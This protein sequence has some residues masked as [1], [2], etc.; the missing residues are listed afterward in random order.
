M[1]TTPS[2][3]RATQCIVA[4]LIAFG[5]FSGCDDDGAQLDGNVFLVDDSPRDLQLIVI[6]PPTGPLEGGALVA[7]VGEGF[8]AEMTVM[9]GERQAT[10]IA[11]GGDSVAIMSTPPGVLPGAVDVV[12]TR[13]SDGQTSTLNG[14]YSYVPGPG[15]LLVLEAIPDEGPVAGGSK[16]T[17]NGS[18]FVEGAEVFFGDKKATG[19]RVLGNEALTL[20]VPAGAAL[21]ATNI[22]VTLPE[23]DSHTLERGYTYFPEG[24]LGKVE[25][26]GV[27]PSTGPLVGGNIVTVEG[28]GFVTGTTVS[29]GNTA[30]T[31]VRVLGPDAITVTV[32]EGTGPGLVEVRVNVPANETNETAVAAFLENAYAYEVEAPTQLS[33]LNVI[34][35]Q[36]PL[37]GG[38]TVALR[39]SGFEEGTKVFF[40][41]MAALNVQQLGANG[42]TAIMPE[43][44]DAGAVD[45]RVEL[46]DGGDAVLLDDGYTYEPGTPPLL[47]LEA[48]PLTGPIEGG[49]VVALKGE[50]FID[51][52]KVYFGGTRGTSVRVL[53]STAITVIAPLSSAPGLVDLRVE[54]PILPGEDAGEAY[55]LEDA[56]TYLLGNV[57]GDLSVNSLF[58]TQDKEEG[59]ALVL[60]TGTGFDPAM[61]VTFGETQS[62]LTQV[63]SGNAATALVPAGMA[64][65]LDVRLSNPTGEAVQ[66]TNGFRYITDD[67]IDLTEPP[68]LGAVQPARGPASGGTIVRISG[69]N[70]ADDARIFFGDVESTEVNVSSTSV[71]SAVVPAGALGS[72]A[73]RVVNPDDQEDVLAN[74]FV[75]AD[76]ADAPT[77]ALTAP[78]TGPTTGGTWVSIDGTGYTTGTTVWFGLIPAATTTVGA[79][80]PGGTPGTRLIAVSPTNP[81]GSVDLTVV[82]TDGAFAVSQDA[83]GYYDATTLPNNP[84]VV[85]SVFPRVGDTLGGAQVSVIGSNF[86][87]AARF[88]FDTTEVTVN[89]APDGSQRIIT[90]AAHDP[91]SVGVTVV[92]PDGLTSTRRDAFIYFAPPPLIIGLTP[93]VSAASGGTEV[94]LTGKNFADDVE[95]RLGTAVISAFNTASATELTF[96]APAQAPGL[97]DVMVLNP[98]G[99]QDISDGAF[100]YVSDDQFSAPVVTSIEPE[101]GLGSGGYNVVIRGDNFQQGATVQFGGVQGSGVNWLTE[102][103]I[104]AI[105]PA[106]TPGNSVDVTVFNS[107]DKSGTLSAAFTYT[108]APIGPI[109]IQTVSPGIGSMSGGTV[110]TIN[111]EGFETNSKVYIDGVESL[112]VDVISSSVMTAVTPAGMPGLVDVRVERPDLTAATAF[113]A[114][115]FYDPATFGDEPA[116]SSV[117]P[118][119]GPLTGNTAVM[120]RGQRF[121]GPVQVFFGAFASP[122][123]TVLDSGR[124]VARTPIASRAGT[125]AVSIINFDGLIG[126]QP[127]GFSYYDASGAT[128]PTLVTVL[129]PDGSVF[130]GNEVTVIGENLSPGA[131]VYICERPATIRGASGGTQLTVVTPPGDPGP[132][133]V[134]VVNPDG[135]TADRADAFNY[136]A[137]NP[138]VSE[139]IPRIGSK[140]GGIDVVVRG[141]NFVPGASVRFGNAE[142]VLVRVADPRTLTATLPPANVGVVDVTVVN[143]GG[144]QSTLAM[145]FEYVDSVTGIPPNIIQ[146]APASGPLAGGTPVQILG[147]NFDPD[148]LV[149]FDQQTL[150]DA[151]FV[152]TSE[153]R[154]VTPAAQGAGSVSLTVLNPDGLG[155][156]VPNGFTFANPQSDPPIITSL[157]PSTGRESGGTTITITGSN[158]SAN[159]TWR[160]GGKPLANVAFVNSSLITARTPPGTPGT[161]DLVY[162]GPDG[163]VAL[164]LQAFEYL[165]APALTAVTPALGGVSGGNQL[166]LVGD[167]FETG[168]Q[169]F[170]GSSPGQVLAVE[171]ANSALVRTPS[172]QVPG[173]VD[174]KIRNPD[175]QEGTIVAG[176]EYLLPPNLTEVWP[177]SGPSPGNTL[178]TLTGTGFHPGSQVFVGPDP[179]G[180]VFYSSA[181]LILAFTPGGSLG[182]T[183]VR[184]LNP[185]QI[186][187]T[188]VGGFTYSD[189]ADLGPAPF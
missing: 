43:G 158:F 113:N 107:A 111:G 103:V 82:R 143:P 9:F 67:N 29:F 41:G 61:T 2:I 22:R 83:F 120:I 46:P 156:T 75:Y 16:A 8:E 161:V 10:Q 85:G 47:I 127:G 45:V 149:L 12:V 50:G 172:A 4:A 124:I 42:L 74:A 89:E 145:G 121:A 114:F 115:A 119:L 176:F 3:L 38:N 138:I 44:T 179:T 94:R 62:P 128:A 168:M 174:V 152:S 66:L 110:V 169:V 21:G 131:R 136:E 53:G 33:L 5:S 97:M 73:V 13:N 26:L 80:T 130:G 1:K 125:V 140:D 77:I 7:L 183:D 178:M 147:Q 155:A 181:T 102:N 134:T 84:P 133:V 162:V 57:A 185:D 65:T 87:P 79:T 151:E 17:L 122:Q 109:K 95:V 60:V 104:T 150:T 175:G 54:L 39:G 189:P 56:Y 153:I 31:D 37:A 112:T 166:T 34:P 159:G 108:S 144:A 30:A 93:A 148:A 167:N 186:D 64:G 23:G 24:P 146:I 160:L 116:I 187:S 78:T 20:T 55:T 98:D 90:T 69:S 19:V 100:L 15:Q 101:S 71:A 135:L 126:V 182:S 171:S 163:Q 59:G 99:Q 142:S 48:I 28:N 105:V 40:D 188:L 137:P 81:V 173:F 68:A 132:C 164:R 27:I 52:A 117:D 96:F 51:G 139:V 76:P 118:G 141:D 6:R 18:G 25:V 123:A 32:P 49:N 35:A 157:V 58:P 129:P 184:V 92:N 91:G 11:V 70:I 170:F 88:F 177:P 165:A 36:G 86:D 154:F 72:V 180:E 106:G 63:L 14:G